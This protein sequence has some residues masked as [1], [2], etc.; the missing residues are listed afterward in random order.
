VT[1]SLKWPSFNP[2]RHG[3]G[4]KTALKTCQR[5]GANKLPIPFLI[6]LN[7]TKGQKPE[8]EGEWEKADEL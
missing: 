3:I 1:F 6:G 2:F 4:S 8:A 7:K 5:I